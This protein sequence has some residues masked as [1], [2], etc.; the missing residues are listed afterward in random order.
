M[1]PHIIAAAEAHVETLG[2]TTV[3]VSAACNPPS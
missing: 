1:Q 2:R 3:A